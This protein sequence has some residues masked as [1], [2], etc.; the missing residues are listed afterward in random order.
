MFV[1]TH[2][3][4]VGRLRLDRPEARNAIPV[5]G[6]TELAE[7]C[8]DAVAG[9]ARLLVLSGRREA[10]CAGADL[11]DFPA[12][13]DDPAAASAFREKMRGGLDAL[14]RLPIATIA[15]VEGPCYGAGVA[16]AMACDIRVAGEGARFAITP[17]KFG[18]S[19]PQEDVARLVALVGPGQASRLLLGAGTIE[20][21][22]AARIGLV[23]FD[24]ADV[25]SAVVELSAAILANS[26]ESVAVL[27]R[28]IRLAV[29]GTM[30]D[31]GQDRDF[32]ALFGSED[33]RARLAALRP[34]R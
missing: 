3:G 18:I 19:Y 7:R 5:A 31:D 4:A 22:E 23:E 16:L 6:W 1:L 12:L 21:A 10:F 9:G 28:A 2:D 32:D 17:A 24:T 15:A 26:G 29:D 11:G 20:A 30:R 8:G 13:T 25:E 33:F 27:K 34:R 14:A